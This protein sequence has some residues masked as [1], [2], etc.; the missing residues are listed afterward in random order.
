MRTVDD[1]LVLVSLTDGSTRSVGTSVAVNVG[2]AVDVE[3]GVLLSYNRGVAIVGRLDRSDQGLPRVVCSPPTSIV[4]SGALVDGRPVILCSDGTVRTIGPDELVP[5]TLVTAPQ[6]ALADLQR[7]DRVTAARVVD[8]GFLLGTL[9]GELLHYVTAREGISAR[10]DVLAEQTELGVL[11]QLLPLSADVEYLVGGNGAP[12]LAFHQARSVSAD[13]GRDDRGP[14]FI[15]RR[16]TLHT[17]GRTYATWTTAADAT[18]RTVVVDEGL[19][20]IDVDNDGAVVVSGANGLV[21]RVDR[22]GHTARA[23]QGLRMTVKQATLIG[24]HALTAGIDAAGPQLWPAQ[25]RSRDDGVALLPEL[26]LRRAGVINDGTIWALGFNEGPWWFQ[27]LPPVDAPTL[28]LEPVLRRTF[29]DGRVTPLNDAV[30]ALDNTGMISKATPSST[31]ILRRIVGAADVAVGTQQQLAVAIDAR[32][33]V[34]DGDTLQ[35]TLALG[36]DRATDVVI[37]D[38]NRW[39]IAGTLHGEVMAWQLD[40]G[41]LVV[42][43]QQHTEQ[44]GAIDVATRDDGA[45]VVMSAGWDHRVR[46]LVLTPV[47]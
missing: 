45:V 3:H 34:F 12:M 15:D 36:D 27:A 8:D 18:P 13:V 38:R 37:D 22:Q 2:L 25:P 28:L 46:S 26:R 35:H 40:S 47:R 32:I 7:L 23:T 44:V 42:K 19:T 43:V 30:V 6:L 21:V 5:T 39:V 17:F 16:G 9:R 29:V 20:S 41:A 1:R 33:E 31:T 10:V 11:N 4:N 14:A 24:D